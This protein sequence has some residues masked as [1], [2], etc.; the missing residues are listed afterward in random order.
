MSIIEDDIMDGILNDKEK[1]PVYETLLEITE[2]SIE[3]IKEK[4][5]SETN[6]KLIK[7]RERTRTNY[8]DVIQQTKERIELKELKENIKTAIDKINEV[9]N[10]LNY[11]EI[12]TILNS[13]NTLVES[14]L[15]NVNLNLQNQ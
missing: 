7:M 3:L 6:N 14:R 12:K 13:V 8:L 15:Q 4:P 2:K 11:R 9:L 5:Q 10:G 1:L